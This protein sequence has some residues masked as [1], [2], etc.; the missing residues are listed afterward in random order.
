MVGV[1]LSAAAVVRRV[2]LDLAG[3]TIPLVGASPILPTGALLGM[4]LAFASVIAVS[5][6]SSLASR[7]AHQFRLMTY[8]GSRLAPKV[9]SNRGLQRLTTFTVQCWALQLFYFGCA[10]VASALHLAGVA[11]PDGAALRAAL[12]AVHIAFEVCFVTS[13]VVTAVVTFVLLPERRRRGDADGFA[14]MLGWRPQLMH[15]ANL[16]F[17]AT[18]LLVSSMPMC[19]A[20][21]VFSML[22]GLQY[23]LGSWWWLQRTGVVYYPFIDPTL[24]PRQSI[25]FHTALL[26][27]F[28]AFFALG[29]AVA[30][31][32]TVLPLAVRAPLLYLAAASIMWTTL[33]PIPG[34]PATIGLRHLSGGADDGGSE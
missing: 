2:P 14:R 5:L 4:R 29:A 8:P 21:A 17:M 3:A 33:L 7:T 20:H 23:L 27:V 6:C 11:T 1:A 22:F 10:A 16:A 31:A 24:P 13:L 12:R 32:A 19:G 18:E 26:A 28:G 9:L 30:R 25:R 15:N 34:R